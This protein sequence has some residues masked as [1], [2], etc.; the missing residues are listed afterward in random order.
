MPDAAAGRHRGRRLLSPAPRRFTGHDAARLAAL[1]WIAVVL[2]L[3]WAQLELHWDAE[4]LLRRDFRCFFEAGR[5]LRA[6]AAPYAGGRM[7][8]LY[9]PFVLPL[10]G[11]TAT[12][13]AHQLYAAVG[14]LMT[15]GLAA[16]AVAAASLGSAPRPRRVT[17]AVLVATSPSFFLGLHLGQPAGVF[18]ALVAG[19][20]AL[21]A[22]GRPAA[23]GALAALLLAKPHFALVIVGL[24]VLLRAWR[25]LAAFAVAALA[26]LALSLPYGLD[27]WQGWLAEVRRVALDHD[28]HP[29]KLWKQFTLYAFLR[30]VTDGLDPAGR[31]AKALYALA[32]L[33]FG[34]TIAVVVHRLR[35]RFAEPMI[36]ARLFA[37]AVLAL[38]ALN[39]YLHYYDALLLAIPAATLALAAPT[40]RRRLAHRGAVACA[41][42]LWVLQ[43]SVLFWQVTP[44]LAGVVTTVW[45]ALELQDL[46]RS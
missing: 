45:L 44:P 19:A 25:F 46:W 1:V 13:G 24:A 38:C 37:V 42:L 23:G 29:A 4:A 35:A 27:A 2:F 32:L 39:L 30:S 16:G 5:R 41:A 10:V 21:W 8:L 9:P 12:L 22:H 7:P 43:L 34:A 6:G 11:A 31:L 20:L 18:L 26:L 40:W 15:L 36:A 17:I 28:A 3:W 33:P 14:A